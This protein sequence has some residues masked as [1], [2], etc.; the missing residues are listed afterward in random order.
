MRAAVDANLAPAP[1]G[2]YVS[3]CWTHEQSVGG[4][5]NMEEPR[6]LPWPTSW[7]GRD[8]AWLR[9]GY[10]TSVWHP[11]L[12]RSL[13]PE[14]AFAAY[15]DS[16]RAGRLPARCAGWGRKCWQVVDNVTYPH[17]P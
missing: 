12:R 1:S 9:Q 10:T 14:A 11:P 17:N 6:W 4:V 3:S 13:S 8:A 16:R 2:M 7:S 15:Y 5:A